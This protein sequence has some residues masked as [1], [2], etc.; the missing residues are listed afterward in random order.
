MEGD[1]DYG[2]QND[3]LMLRPSLSLGLLAAKSKGKMYNKVETKT[4]TKNSISNFYGSN[5]P[6]SSAKLGLTST[7]SVEQGSLNNEY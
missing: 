1:S 3:C 5:G 6:K 2:G 7:F 4:K